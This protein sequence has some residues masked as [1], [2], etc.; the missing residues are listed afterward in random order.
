MVEIT[1]RD[2]IRDLF[3]PFFRRAIKNNK[4]K[5]IYFKFATY[6]VTKG[7]QPPFS[8]SL[9]KMESSWKYQRIGSKD[10][11]PEL[12][13]KENS[14]TIELFKDVLPYLNK[15]SPILEIGCNAGRSLNYLYKLG[16]SVYI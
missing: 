14:L 12:Y 6:L 7:I 13:L 4:I 10:R 2:R 3:L 1:I 9:R 11:S 16:I 8:S 5:Y 15:S